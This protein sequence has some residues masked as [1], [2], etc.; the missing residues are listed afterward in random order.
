MKTKIKYQIHE[1]FAMKK[2]EANYYIN[3]IIDI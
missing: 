2:K 3:E 1:K